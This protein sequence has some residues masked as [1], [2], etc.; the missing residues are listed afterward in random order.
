[1]KTVETKARDWFRPDP[2]QP[3]TTYDA[4][5]LDRLG[6]DMVARGVLVPLLAREEGDHGI[7]IDGWRR[8][9]AAGRMGIKEL[10]VIIA[11]KG[12]T[13][14]EI[15]GIQIATAIHRADLTGHEK[16]L[17]CAELMRMN[18]QW[19]LAEL[20]KFLHLSAPSITKLMSPSKC[21]LGWQEALAAGRVGISDCYAASGLP[22][23]DQAALLA[24]KLSGASR[25][26]IVHAGRKSRNGDTPAVKVTRVKL[27]LP[28]GVCIVASGAG[29]SLDDLIV[30]LSQAGI[31]AKK[32]RSMDQ[33]IKSFQAMM[34]A[35]NKKRSA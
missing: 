17:A 6:D 15:R 8:W 28:S 13:E 5:E 14:M 7:I 2:K 25:D 30:S 21:S 23:A 12:Q 24:L 26:E 31:E 10:P 1:V 9:L 3:R 34:I 19:Q 27:L 4:E 29:L 33:D 11:G 32:A 20:A 16:W 22:E 18:P 35:R